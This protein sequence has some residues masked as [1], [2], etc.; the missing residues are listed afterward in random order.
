MDTEK[1]MLLDESPLE[2]D[3]DLRQISVNHARS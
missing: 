1:I 3:P 2:N